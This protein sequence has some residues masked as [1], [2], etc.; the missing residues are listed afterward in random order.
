M[1]IELLIYNNT[2]QL[3]ANII[4]YSSY[5]DKLTIISNSIKVPITN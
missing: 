2:Y 3:V 5:Y 1:N 4:N